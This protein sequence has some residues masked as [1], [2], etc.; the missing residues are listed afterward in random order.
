M[1]A[2]TPTTLKNRLPLLDVYRGFAMI[3]VLIG[4]IAIFSGFVF[5]PFERL[6]QMHLS[7]IN[8]ILYRITMIVISG[9]FYP[10]LMLLFGAGL[11]IQFQKRQ[12][13]GFLIFSVRRL[14]ILLLIG[15]VHLF[16]WAGDVVSNYAIYALL[17]IPLRNFNAKNYL[18]LAIGLF[19]VHLSSL[20]AIPY[21]GLPKYNYMNISIFN[22]PDITPVDLIDTVRHDGFKGLQTVTLGQL[23]F[24]YSGERI[25]R[26]TFSSLM[27]FA[28]G[29]WLIGSGF[30]LNQIHKIK[31]LVS[32]FAIGCIGTYLYYYV[33]P[34]FKIID[35]LFLSLAYLS[36]IAMIF[37]TNAGKRIL[38][39]LI[40]LGRMALTTY[41]MQSIIC[42]VIFYGVGFGLFAKVSL[43]AVYLIAI[44]ILVLQ[45]QFSKIWLRYYNY[46]PLEGLWRKLSYGFTNVKIKNN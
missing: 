24:L 7:G 26:I 32:F 2:F 31:Y 1:S 4:N 20:Y 40:P 12:N 44:L 6:D 15:C 5:I 33:W 18:F 27:M 8:Q 38:S 35:N 28:A 13:A 25:I 11:F 43:Y 34:G 30:M 16:F 23:S 45:L 22:L 10:I 29:A 19:L 17:F 37:R 36:A 9:K 39:S 42:I 41:I 46:G 14:I 3:G 21:L